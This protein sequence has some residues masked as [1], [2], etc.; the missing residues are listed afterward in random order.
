[1][2]APSS[3]VTSAFCDPVRAWFEDRFSEPTEP[4]REGWPAIARG[5]DVLIAAPTGSGKTLA[6]FLHVLDRLTRRALDG[7]LKERLYAVYVSPLRALSHDIQRNLEVPL[8]GIREVP[9]G[10]SAW[11][12]KTAVRTGDTPQRERAAML[13]RPP[14]VLVTTPE[15]LFLLLTSERAR[16]MLASVETVIVDEIH[17]LARDKRGTHLALTLER[18]EAHVAAQGNPRP[19]RIGLSAT[20]R[21]MDLLARF[22]VGVDPSRPPAA[23]LDLGH[24]RDLDLLVRVPPEEELMAV[25]PHEQWEAMLKI[26]AE[27]VSTHTTTLVFVNQRRMAERVAHRLGERLGEGR[28]SAHHGS[29]SRER[30]HRVEERLKSGDLDALVATASLELGIDIG[31]VDL[32]CQIGSPRSIATLL[33]RIGRSGHA[34]G[35]VPK[36]VVFPT[37]RDELVECAALMRAIRGGRL[38][39]IHPPV[40]ALDILAQQI[41]AATG[42][43]PWSEDAL[44]DL[45]RRSWPYEHLPRTDFD[46]ILQMLSEGF[47]TPR[48]RRGLLVHRDRI[49]GVVHGRRGARLAALTSGGAIPDQGDYRV[50]LDPDETVVGSVNEDWA[51]ESMAGD[52]FLLGSHSWRIRRVENGTV[53]VV[54]AEGAPPTIPFWFGEAPGR[55]DELS[56]EVSDLRTWVCSLLEDAPDTAA[57][58]IA[59]ECAVERNGAEQIAHY[60]RIQRESTGIVPTRNELLAERFFDDSGGMQLV[61]HAPYG[62]RVNRGFGLALRKRFCRAF[63]MELQAAA[64]DDA[65]VLSLGNPQTFDLEDIRRFLAPETLRDV[66]S[67]AML[68]S[69][70]FAARWRWNATRALA[71]LRRRGGRLV[72]FNIQRMEADDLLAA[73][74]PD[75][76]ACQEHVAYPIDVPDHPLVSQT[77]HD[78]LHEASDIDGLTRLVAALRAGEVKMHVIDTVEASPFSH[79]IL[80]ARPYAFLDD[81]PLEER[82]TR[83][84]S[85]RHVLPEKAQD[86]AALDPHAIARVREEVSPDVRDE[87]ELHELL[88][89]VV[90]LP[91]H[92]TEP[93]RRA[94]LNPE[95]VDRLKDQGRAAVLAAGALRWLVATERRREAE[96]LQ[97]SG[98]FAPDVVLPAALDPGPVPRGAA[99]DR[100]TRGHVGFLGPVAEPRL[101]RDLG[102]DEGDLAGATARLQSTGVLLRGRFDSALDGPQACDRRLLARIHRY[103]LETLR[104]QIR[105]VSAQAYLRFLIRWQHVHPD[106]RAGGEGGLLQVLERLAGWEAPVAAWESALLPDR[107]EAYSPKL[108]DALCLGGQ[109]AWGR[110]A[111]GGAAQP[112]RATPVALWP[113]EDGEDLLRSL[114]TARTS[115]D[116]APLRG[117]GAR[118]LEVLEARGALFAEEVRASAGLLPSELDDGLR[119]LV[120]AGW[121][122]SDGFAPLRRLVRPPRRHDRRRTKSL[123]ERA[124]R[125]PA[126]RWVVMR[127][128]G[129]DED[130]DERAEHAATRLLQRYGVVFRDLVAREALPCRWRDVRRALMRLEARGVIR[131]G[132]FV[133]GFIGEH[134]ALPEAIP[135]LRAERDRPKTEEEII[136]SAVDPLNLAGIL[137]PGPRVPARHTLRL[138]LRDGLPV[139]IEERGVRTELVSSAAQG[140][141]GTQETPGTQESG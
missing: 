67:Q 134:F 128:L 69:P 43:E 11:G 50:I 104:K 114:A 47:E 77:I 140:M 41:V 139:A 17:A 81:A 70:I 51:V 90:L 100:A 5:E 126:G 52:I 137:V 80:N 27:L 10:E 28:V 103:T 120:A 16:E 125:E 8:A 118:V 136:V 76:T 130:A 40:G 107:V 29:L 48:G 23:V 115:D 32:V 88:H 44:F 24:Q 34:L 135:L 42:S 6:A 63:N 54:D 97:P 95:V 84:V 92:N 55:T 20:Q 18:L 59:A 86:L 39:S 61:V 123:V 14:H 15:S 68:G 85:L 19:Q 102:V 105:P 75:Q 129:L 73:A 132:R 74:F 12:V 110:I 31:H 96:A 35:L 56:E 133:A 89:D 98:T 101:A 94:L 45:V 30:R 106:T 122:T 46:R 53:R 36:G 127:P 1:M 109:I 13:R 116:A 49:R 91:L 22:L 64:S 121:V 111:P 62:A 113:R 87:E 99:L 33:Q 138:V 124:W 21:P 65:V 93:W 71:V 72:P 66:L 4:Q 57:D 79:E 83:A 25:A 37:T 58:V 3:V 26:V 38:D 60:V 141:G 108:L 9:G 82:K 112:S 117:P 131:G 7:V 119:E 2:A 78:C